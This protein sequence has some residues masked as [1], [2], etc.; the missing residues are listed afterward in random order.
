M[1]VQ[2]IPYRQENLLL[3]KFLEGS[4]AFL[5]SVLICVCAWD[6]L[7]HH[8][9]LYLQAGMAT[10]FVATL[11]ELFSSHIPLISGLVMW[12]VLSLA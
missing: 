11:V 4:A 1:T 9:A 10:A 12:L 8:T 3:N 5:V 7:F 6:N 2:N